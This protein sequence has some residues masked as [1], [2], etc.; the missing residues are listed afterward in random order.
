MLLTALLQQDLKSAHL[1][2]KGQ[3][4]VLYSA[5]LLCA[6]QGLPSPNLLSL[7]SINDKKVTEVNPFV[8]KEF[9][10]T[11]CI[12]QNGKGVQPQING[13]VAGINR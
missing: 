7:Y 11:S 1:E 3:H 9:A 12:P 5:A 4:P 13:L 8:V 2:V 6:S 10:L